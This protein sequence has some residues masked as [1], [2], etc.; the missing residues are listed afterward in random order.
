MKSTAQVS[1][2]GS[3]ILLFEKFGNNKRVSISLD[4]EG[5]DLDPN[6]LQ[7]LSA[8]NTAIKVSITLS[9]IIHDYIDDT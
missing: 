7:S 2:I 8:G 6:S 9:R 4:P 1:V 5:P 3:L